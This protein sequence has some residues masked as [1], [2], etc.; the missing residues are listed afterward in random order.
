M[1]YMGSQRVLKWRN[2]KKYFYPH[3]LRLSKG[4]NKKRK[5]FQIGEGGHQGVKKKFFAF[6][7]ESHHFLKKNYGKKIT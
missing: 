5:L 2:L 1:L 3:N 4:F 7:D 6:L